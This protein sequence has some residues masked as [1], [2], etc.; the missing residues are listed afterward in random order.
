[1]K[2]LWE[3]ILSAFG[4]TPLGNSTVF[5]RTSSLPD[6]TGNNGKFLKTDGSTASWETVAGGGDLLSTN[7][8]SDVANA[9]TARSNLGLAI[10]TNVQ[11]YDA[12]LADVA[13][14]TPSDGNFIVGDGTNFVAESGA[15][16]RTSLGLGSM[17]TA[18]ATDYVAKAAYDAQTILAATAD[19]TPAALTVGEQTL[20][21]RVT[22]GNVAAIAIDS[23]I[24]ATSSSHDT[25]P[26]ALA[27]KTVTDGKENYHGVQSYGT[28]SF[29]NSTHV[30][31]LAAGTNTY[32][33]QGVKYTT[34]NAITCDLDDYVTLTANTLYFVYFDDATGTLKASDTVWDLKTKVPVATVFWNGSAGSVCREYHNHTRDLDWHTN[35]HLTI[36]ARYYSGLDKTAP[37]TAADATLTITAGAIYDEDLVSTIAQQTTSRI[38]YQVSSGVY[39]FVDSSLP[40]AGSSGDPKWL[41]TDDY[42]LKSVDNNDHVCMWV[43]ATPD[44][45]RPI[46]IIPTQASVAPS[47]L[48]TARAEA[49]PSLA[50]LNLAPE[51]KL[52]WKFIYKGDG[53]FQE[54]VD[55]RNASVLPAGGTASTTASSVSFVPS[56]NIA[57]TTVQTAIEELDSEKA[58]VAQTMYI[59]TTQVAINRASAALTLAGITL[60]TP[61]IGTPSAGTLTNC[62]G[63]P[64]S[65]VTDS[66][67]EALGVGSIEL[68]HASDTTITR[69]SAGVIAVE[70]TN[71]S[72]A[73]HTHEGT[74][75]LSTGEAGGVK[76]LREDGDGTSSWQTPAYPT[77]DSLGLDT[78]DSPQFTAINLGHAS[79]TTIARVSAGVV[80]IEGSN[81]LTAATG[82]ALAG[83]TMTGNITL[84]ENAS[85]DL[86]PSLSADGK[87][88]GTCIT[89]TAG[90]TLAFGDIVYY[91]SSSKWVLAD[92]DAAS[93]G[94]TVMLGV[95]VLAAS[96]DTEPTKVLLH[97]NVR[98]DTAFPT[99]T[100]GGAVYLSTT[101]GDITQTA[102]T[103]ADDVVRVLGHA[104]TA[105]SI[106][107]MPSPSH[108]THTG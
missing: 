8:L 10:G 34:A 101:D 5:K 13:G 4:R 83:G 50:G 14:L 92:A 85:V 33:Y 107:F 86:D 20:V 74:A 36:G 93:T 48:A 16:A 79:D 72:L 81:I 99:L 103:G 44:I 25:I 38:W 80:S 102:P 100:V 6:Q 97:G 19:N 108:I 67:S 23:D 70:G 95:C 18:T 24:A 60:T 29:N 59:G 39:T 61:D 30:V 77:R 27:V 76:F 55:Y 35:A 84:G 21:G 87:Y 11:A 63:L 1:M 42:T 71:V 75:I 49:P 47:L 37:T 53:E 89:G 51:M 58:A 22:G 104:L 91:N 56:G 43:Y 106:V 64:L 57:A 68:G 2:S 40:Y 12:Q 73:G 78:D 65:G 46:H 105:D 7:N 96:G 28:L 66:T 45:D 32:W 15:T 62:S 54:A 90:A 31:Q 94:G 41:D 9:T 3:A 26:S 82:L 69:V 17:A 88:T 52:I 98:A